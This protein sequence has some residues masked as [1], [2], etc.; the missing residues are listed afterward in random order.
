MENRYISIQDF[1][2]KLGKEESYDSYLRRLC[3][4]DKLPHRLEKTEKDI[5]K[6]MIDMLSEHAQKLIKRAGT[7]T[8]TEQD[9]IDTDFEKVTDTDTSTEDRPR[10]ENPLVL[11]E[12]N[13]KLHLQ[14]YEI[15]T[16]RALRAEI[17][18]EYVEEIKELEATI[19]TLKKAIEK[20]RKKKFWQ[21]NV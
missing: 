8:G 2:K 5:D 4:K 16:E 21:R 7:D 13:N 12:N 1:R 18:L 15:L 10:I 20:E 17:R 19:E 14:Q 11:F 3:R 9:C 6:Y